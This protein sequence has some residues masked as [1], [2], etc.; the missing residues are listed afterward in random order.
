MVRIR[1]ASIAWDSGGATKVPP[2]IWG[3]GLTSSRADEDRHPLVDLALV[4]ERATVV[5]YDAHG[6]GESS[7]LLEP[8]RGSWSELAIDQIELIDYLGIDQVVL[9]GASM[10][11][12]TAL[13]SALML[14]D[15]VRGLLLVIPPTGWDERAAQIAIYGQM[16]SIID[17]KGVEPI[18]RASADQPPPDPFL[19]SNEYREMRAESMRATDPGRLA[20]VLRGA[21]HADLPPLES[22]TRLELPTLVL[23]WT[24]DTGHP[25]STA[26]ALGRVLPRC[27]VV[28]SSTASELRTWT[29]RAIAFLDGI[30]S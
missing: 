12:A 5:R 26:E 23:A 29:A 6:H 19:G 25:V 2:L 13:H 22:L 11:A 15:R 18:I 28:I 9:G 16:A 4:R 27:E 8:E 17:A 10:G 3:H 7:M 14:A 21:A 1:G 20:A 24:G 30:I